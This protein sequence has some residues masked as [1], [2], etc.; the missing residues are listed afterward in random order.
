MITKITTL[1]GTL[2]ILGGL[3]VVV[4]LELTGLVLNIFYTSIFLGHSPDLCSTL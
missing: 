3:Y 2:L 1:I 4:A